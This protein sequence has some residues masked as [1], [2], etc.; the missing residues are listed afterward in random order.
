MQH[1]PIEYTRGIQDVSIVSKIGETN[2][3]KSV[4]KKS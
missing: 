2:I 4:V 1:L 3:S